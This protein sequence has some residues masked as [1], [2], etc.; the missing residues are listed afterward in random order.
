MHLFRAEERQI[1]SV[2][3]FDSHAAKWQ[4]EQEALLRKIRAIQHAAPAPIDQAIDTMDLV[5]RA[6][7]LFLEQ[8]GAERR[9]LIQMVIE[10]ATWKDGMLQTSLFEPFE[11]LRHSNQESFRKEK[12]N[13]GS[14][15]DLEVWLPKTDTDPKR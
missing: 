15:R 5:S 3:Q 10:K 13:D 2:P 6:S 12:E 11:L 7:E 4:V 8:S 9:R 14:G 1:G